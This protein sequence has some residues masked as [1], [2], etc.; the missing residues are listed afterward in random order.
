MSKT[1]DQ[2]YLRSFLRGMSSP[3]PFPPA[4]HGEV[5]KVDSETIFNL[6]ESANDTRILI[7]KKNTV[8]EFQKERNRHMSTYHKDKV[9]KDGYVYWYSKFMSHTSHVIMPHSLKEVIN[10]KVGKEGLVYIGI[11]H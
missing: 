9:D 3:V 7:I 10:K 1:S 8:W 5:S 4:K 11:I 6:L 2:F